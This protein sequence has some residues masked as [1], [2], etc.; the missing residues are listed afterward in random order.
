MAAPIVNIGLVSNLFSRQMH[1]V[2]AGDTEIGHTH[3]FDHLTLL[4][5]GILNITVDG[6]T[7]E[8]TAPQMIFIKKDIVHELTAVTDNTVAYCIHPLKESSGDIIDASMVP[9]GDALKSVL[10][11]ILS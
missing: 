8:F 9:K 10:Q 5:K 4:A 2:N 1:F 7:T 3:A 6:V 11:N